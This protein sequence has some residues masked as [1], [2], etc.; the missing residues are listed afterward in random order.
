VLNLCY[1]EVFSR[2]GYKSSQRRL[3]FAYLQVLCESN[4]S[5]VRMWSALKVRGVE[6]MCRDVFV[7]EY[8]VTLLPQETF[9]S[10]APSVNSSTLLYF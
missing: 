10:S 8:E 7:S 5:V 4:A 3:I 1:D 6:W 2:G 9:A